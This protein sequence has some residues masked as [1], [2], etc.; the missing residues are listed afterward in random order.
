[1]RFILSGMRALAT[2]RSTT[3]NL[4]HICKFQLLTAI[5]PT[6]FNEL[7]NS[8]QATRMYA[9]S[10]AH[11]SVQNISSAKPKI[12]VAQMTSGGNIE[13][14]F[15]TVKNLA[16][17]AVSQGAKILFLPENF[18]FLGM[19]FTESLAVAEPLNGPII[20]RYAALAKNLDIW[21]SLG[22]FQ[23]RGPDPDHLYNC[24]VVI[25][26]DG[27]IAASYRK[28]HLFNVDV[29]GGP[30][31]MESRFTSP[32]TGLTTCDSPVGRLGLSV[33]Y[34]L[35]FPAVYQRLAFELGAEIILVPS[36]FTVATGQAHWEVLL[37]ARAI[38]T[39]TYVV[40]AAQAGKHNEKRESYGH[41]LIIDPWG[42]VVARLDDPLATGIAVAEVDL[43]EM[44]S[45]RERMPVK[46]HRL[47]GQ[48]AIEKDFSV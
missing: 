3:N 15:Q 43:E 38:E 5:P 6:P 39:Q 9:S 26:A 17:Q 48:G 29:P 24:H 36:A 46:E 25:N 8:L 12:A 30:V 2:L 19:S 23:E 22:G 31:L 34:D 14:N 41:S 35:R 11:A 13:T 33:C 16:E 42:R 28:I 20:S 4:D 47:A 7:F 21:L 1:M 44:K 27:N 32:G 40:A 37:R 10:A 18:N 45:I